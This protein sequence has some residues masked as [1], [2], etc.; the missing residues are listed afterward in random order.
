MGACCKGHEPA[1]KEAV[2]QVSRANSGQKW[3]YSLWASLNVLAR[4]KMFLDKHV[5]SND[6]LQNV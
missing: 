2:N 3:K 1:L 4:L 6:L 5:A